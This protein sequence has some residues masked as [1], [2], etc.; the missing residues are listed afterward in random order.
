MNVSGNPIELFLAFL[1][2][3]AYSFTPCVYPL[4]PITVGFIGAESSGSRSKGFWL[5]FVYVTGIAF[6][7]SSLGALAGLTG[8]LFGA[9]VSNPVTVVAMGAVIIFLGFVMLDWISLKIPLPIKFPSIRK[10]NFISV[11]ILGLLSAF[12][13]TPCATPVLGSILTYLA[14]KE[15]VVFGICLLLSFSYGMGLLLIVAGTFSAVLAKLPKT[16]KWMLTVKRLYALV[17]IGM[18]IYLLITGIRRF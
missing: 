12:V 6:A 11:F 15:N 8:R 7:Y 17:I 18:G 16:G 14:K 3:I 10:K 1:G 2:G 5:S 9:F 4:V 13:I